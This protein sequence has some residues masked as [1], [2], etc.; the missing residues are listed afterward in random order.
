[1]PLTAPLPEPTMQSFHRAVE[2]YFHPFSQEVGAIWQVVCPWIE[3][4][5]TPTIQATIGVYH[6]HFPSLCVTLRPNSPPAPLGTESG[7]FRLDWVETF[8]TGHQSLHHPPEHRWQPETLGGEVQRLA[9]QFRRFAMPLITSPSTDWSEI[10]RYV[11]AGVE[12]ALAAR[13]GHY[14][15]DRNA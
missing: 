15:F 3:G 5:S 13:R 10:Q 4:F 9:D 6:G 8:V 2:R 1:M 7:V 14:G 12:K 11:Q